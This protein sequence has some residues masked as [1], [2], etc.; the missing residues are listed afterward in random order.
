MVKLSTMLEMQKAGALKVDLDAGTV[1]GVKASEEQ[2]KNAVEQLGWKQKYVSNLLLISK[3][4]KLLR[5]LQ[6][7]VKGCFR[8]NATIELYNMRKSNSLDSFDRILLSDGRTNLTILYNM[9][10]AGG[11][12]VMYDRDRSVTQP[13][14]KKSNLGSIVKYINENYA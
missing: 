9:S 13:I 4:D 14:A 11:K 3:T 7:I 2:L 10:D 6:D 1:A 8:E 12:Y 5:G